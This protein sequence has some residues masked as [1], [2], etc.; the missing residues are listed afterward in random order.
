[1]LELVAIKIHSASP[2]SDELHGDPP[3]AAEVSVKCVPLSG[4]H[5]ARERT[6]QHEV[7]RLERAANRAEL[8]GKPRNPECR[9]AEHAGCDTGF[10]D[11]GV[12]VH[13]ASDPTQVHIHGTN[14]TTADDD[15]GSCSVIGD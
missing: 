10:L 1:M 2:R 5:D 13:D 9:M 3:K 11:L 15:T 7:P 6:G 14:R 12:D 8:V 4:E